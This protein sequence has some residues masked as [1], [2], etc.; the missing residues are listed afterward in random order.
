[1]LHQF[2]REIC[3]DSSSDAELQHSSDIPIQYRCQGEYTYTSTNVHVY[4]NVTYT[5]EPLYNRKVGAE[6]FIHYSECPL[7]GG[8]II[9][10]LI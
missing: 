7:L 10:M 4:A 1:M 5:V 2:E 6:D 3:I 8:F 9:I